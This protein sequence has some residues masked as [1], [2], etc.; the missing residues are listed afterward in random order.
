MDTLGGKELE[1]VMMGGRGVVGSTMGYTKRDQ[2]GYSSISN[3]RCIR[4]VLGGL[5]NPILI[6]VDT[7]K[8]VGVRISYYR[9]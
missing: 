7:W 4:F 9:G 5:Y 1:S 2:N 3:Q 6:K 8:E